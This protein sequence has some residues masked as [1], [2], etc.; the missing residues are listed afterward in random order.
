M[1][2]RR[3]VNGVELVATVL[4]LMS[5]WAVDEKAVQQRVS[6]LENNDYIKK[7]PLSPDVYIY[8]P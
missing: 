5:E 7:D 6:E 1:K 4:G 8:V 3:R 2:K